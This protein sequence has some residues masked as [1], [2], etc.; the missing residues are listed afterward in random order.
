MNPYNRPQPGSYKNLLVEALR[1]IGRETEAQ[2]FE[3]G[4]MKLAVVSSITGSPKLFP[5]LT[6]VL[7]EAL[8]NIDT[9]ETVKYY[10]YGLN[11]NDFVAA[12]TNGA[13]VYDAN[14]AKAVQ[15]VKDQIEK[16]D[17]EIVAPFFT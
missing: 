2:E 9:T 6:D 13:Y 10:I 12:S 7:I 15:Y 4:N 11:N 14:D 8:A 5:E 1:K 17:A 3:N 16:S